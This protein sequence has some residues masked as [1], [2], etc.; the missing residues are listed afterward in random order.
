MFIFTPLVLSL[1]IPAALFIFFGALTSGDTIVVLIIGLGSATV[2]GVEFDSVGLFSLDELLF[3]ELALLLV[4]DSMCCLL[5]GG[6]MATTFFFQRLRQLT[7][8]VA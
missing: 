7:S 8:I 2:T 1:L 3:A 5:G 6:S 4:A